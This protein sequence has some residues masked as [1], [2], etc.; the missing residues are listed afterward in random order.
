MRAQ[1]LCVW[2]FKL[3]DMQRHH[4]RPAVLHFNNDRYG[5]T[6]S[7]KL[8]YLE[9]AHVE[10][11][12]KDL[13]LVTRKIISAAIP[14]KSG[15]WWPGWGTGFLLLIVPAHAGFMT[16]ARG[17]VPFYFAT[18]AHPQRIACTARR[19]ECFARIY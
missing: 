6:N 18:H 17:N 1:E 2:L 15:D 7:T 14:K 8:E 12:L 4:I 11:I 9:D 3:R 5:L 16:Y 19:D 13:P 10:E